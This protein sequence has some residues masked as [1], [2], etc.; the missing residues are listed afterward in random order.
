MGVRVYVPID[1][2]IHHGWFQAEG[3]SRSGAVA[4]D[5]HCDEQGDIS[6]EGVVA[7]LSGET[8]LAHVYD[9]M[10]TRFGRVIGTLDECL[11]EKE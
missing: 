2:K 5:H 8:S 9:G 7:I 1:G 11:K 4:P 3:E 6:A 10:V